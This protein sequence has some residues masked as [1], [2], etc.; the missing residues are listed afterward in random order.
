[1]PSRAEPRAGVGKGASGAGD[2]GGRGNISNFPK[3][4]SVSCAQAHHQ[5]VFAEAFEPPPMSVKISKGHLSS[6]C[7][8]RQ[9]ADYAII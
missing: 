5:K 7:P 6:N 3:E 9:E 4:F 1:L 2:W 8:L